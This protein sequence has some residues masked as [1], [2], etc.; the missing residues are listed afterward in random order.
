MLMKMLRTTNSLSEAK[1]QPHRY[2]VRTG[3]LPTFGNPTEP[4][5]NNFGGASA[6]RAKIHQPAAPEKPVRDG[7][8][9]R[10]NPFATQGAP[11]PRTPVQ[12]ELSLDRVKPV[13]NDLS[14][15][16]L[17]LVATV[18]K[19]PATPGM[20]RIGS[21][22]VPVVKVAPFWERVRGLFQRAGR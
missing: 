17:E 10:L 21:V 18:K 2:K 9:K 8:A 20:V 4:T 1:D 13:R 19:P 5:V 15:T 14:D 11:I 12:G 16:D 3:G 7:W 22:D 6:A